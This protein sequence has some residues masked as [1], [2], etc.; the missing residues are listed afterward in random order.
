MTPECVPMWADFPQHLASFTQG[1]GFV[2]GA[3]ILFFVVIGWVS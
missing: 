2:T 1:F 3:V